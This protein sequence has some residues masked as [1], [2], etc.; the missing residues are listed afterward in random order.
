MSLQAVIAR[1]DTMKY[2]VGDIICHF[3]TVFSEKTSLSP[4]TTLYCQHNRPERRLFIVFPGLWAYTHRPNAAS[5][6][7]AQTVQI[8][9]YLAPCH[10]TNHA[11]SRASRK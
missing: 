1:K 3:F 2:I 11:P 5:P 6:I 9:C 7:L 4:N 10:F 8:S